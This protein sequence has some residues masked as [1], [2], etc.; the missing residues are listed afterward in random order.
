[1]FELREMGFEGKDD[2]L[3]QI[4]D[5]LG[6]KLLLA[7][8]NLGINMKAYYYYQIVKRNLKELISFIESQQNN[9][10]YIDAIEC[11]RL[12]FNFSDTL[13]SY[14]NYF[15][16]NYKDKFSIL[17]KKFYD[18]NFEYRFLYNL[19]NY[20]IHEDLGVLKIGKEYTIDAI[21][22]KFLI[23]KDK[24]INSKRCQKLFRSELINYQ[25]NNNDIDIYII[26][27]NFQEILKKLQI[28]MIFALEDNL[29]SDFSLLM[30]HVPNNQDVFLIEN[31]KILN[32]LLNVSTKFYES[33]ANNFIYS[34][35]LLQI[36]TSINKL[37][38][39]FSF[40]YYKKHGV[41]CK[42]QNNS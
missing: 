6:N 26:I 20:I 9:H 5:E 37:F 28:K 19:R 15:E 31:N 23:S 40:L 29:I 24:L 41:I 36:D 33:L 34:D 21:R 3:T 32:S 13:Y 8:K 25:I 7:I 1:M 11:N 27:S 10:N 22:I 2:F 42:S 30:Q 39:K 38:M 14:I 16:K 35:N 17:K 4:N 12:L 18:N